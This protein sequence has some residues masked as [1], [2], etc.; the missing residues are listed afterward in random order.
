VLRVSDVTKVDLFGL[1][2]EKIYI[3]FSHARLRY[4]GRVGRA[5]SRRSCAARTPIVG[6][7]HG[8]DQGRAACGARRRRPTSAESLRPALQ[9][10]RPNLT[11]ADFA[12]IKRGYQDPQQI[13]MRFKGKPVIGL[14]VVMAPGGNVQTWARRSTR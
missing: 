12:E 6:L 1:Q 4:A 2:D 7:R 10:Q 13:S 5:R 3:E 9:R 11:L 14:G 8:R